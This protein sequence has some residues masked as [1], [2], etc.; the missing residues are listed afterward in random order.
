MK[1]ALEKFKRDYPLA[2]PD[3]LQINGDFGNPFLA[4]SESL[5][6]IT[7]QLALD[8]LSMASAMGRK[9]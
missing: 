8:E 1:K 4:D 6:R 3:L 9:K 2:E 7:T 5:E